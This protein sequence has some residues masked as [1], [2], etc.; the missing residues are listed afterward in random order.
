MSQLGKRFVVFFS[1]VVAALSRRCTHLY[2]FPLF[3]CNVR[4]ARLILWS[5]FMFDLGL[6]TIT[7]VGS[8]RYNI[9]AEVI[10]PF[11]S[12]L[13]ADNAYIFPVC[14]VRRARSNMFFLF[15]TSDLPRLQSSVRRGR[16]FTHNLFLLSCRCRVPSMHRFS[17]FYPCMH[18]Y[19]YD[20]AN[21]V[22]Y[23]NDIYT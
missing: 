15:L 7:I 6:T 12:L 2:L 16:T 19:Y 17:Q 13:W 22:F 1:F 8:P 4:R 9:Y 18:D 11:L 20:E 3:E 5:S 23:C 14:T 10:L 21:Y